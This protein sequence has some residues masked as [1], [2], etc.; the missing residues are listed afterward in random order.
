[1]K[2]PEE[3]LS[4]NQI[5]ELKKSISTNFPEVKFN[6]INIKSLDTFKKNIQNIIQ[7][8]D[9][10]SVVAAENILENDL[11]AIASGPKYKAVSIICAWK[12][13]FKMKFIIFVQVHFHKSDLYNLSIIKCD[14]RKYICI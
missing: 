13:P 4:K 10:A 9:V 3:K 1:M 7:G 8:I 11:I 5:N 12:V 6:L 2:C 14:S